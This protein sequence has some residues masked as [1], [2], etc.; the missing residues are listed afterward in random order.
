MVL[1]F[2]LNAGLV[3]EATVQAISFGLS[4]D[5]SGVYEIKS[6]ELLFLPQALIE[7]I[8][9]PAFVVIGLKPWTSIFQFRRT[10]S[11]IRFGNIFWFISLLSATRKKFPKINLHHSELMIYVNFHGSQLQKLP[12]HMQYYL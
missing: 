10:K 1:Q 12:L 3:Y 4:S 5:R 2:K 6:G 11:R 7:L 8:I 9:D